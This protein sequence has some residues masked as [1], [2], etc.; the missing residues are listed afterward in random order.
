[1]APLAA[2][3]LRGGVSYELVHLALAQAQDLFVHVACCSENKSSNH[4]EHCGHI[5][6]LESSDIIHIDCIIDDD[7][8]NRIL[9]DK[10]SG[11]EIITR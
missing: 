10:D 7:G 3:K 1:M 5:E 8:S 11:G 2:H 4:A 9:K 6:S